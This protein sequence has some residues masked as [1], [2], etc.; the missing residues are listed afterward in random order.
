[1][2]N[3]DAIIASLQGVRNELY[4][5]RGSLE[6]L[7]NVLPS[8]RSEVDEKV[9]YALEQADIAIEEATKIEDRVAVANRGLTRKLMIPMAV[10]I[11]FAC[12]N[13][14]AIFQAKSAADRTQ[15]SADKIEDCLSPDGQCF[16]DN[17]ASL[18][19]FIV[20]IVERV[21]AASAKEHNQNTVEIKKLFCD[22]LINAELPAPPE[23]TEAP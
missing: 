4:N 13:L 10:L 9:Q 7:N 11:V 18:D 8:L 17:R 21:N 3:E 2:A 19:P 22:A 14:F 15:Q 16:K 23:C 6:K 5:I 12:I 20:N 1:M